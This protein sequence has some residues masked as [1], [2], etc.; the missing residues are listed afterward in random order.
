VLGY[1]WTFVTIHAEISLV[2]AAI[3]LSRFNSYLPVLPV[4]NC[5]Y[6]FFSDTSRKVGQVDDSF[7]MEHQGWF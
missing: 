3:T 5:S 4:H 1:V 2:L 6:N 7:V